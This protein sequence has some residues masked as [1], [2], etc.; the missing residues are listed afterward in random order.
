MNEAVLKAGL[1]A[2]HYSGVSEAL[3]PMTRGMGV[4]FMLHHIAPA[5]GKA[6]DPNGLLSITP[7]FLAASVKRVRERGWDIVSIGEAVDRL[8]AGPSPN[9]R[10]FAVFTIDDGYRDNLTEAYPVMKAANAPFT[11]YV[12]SALPQGEA[13]L[14]WI[15]LEEVIA[16]NPVIEFQDEVIACDSIEGKHAAWAQL[17]PII[18]MAPEDQQRAMVRDL[19]ARY[20]VSQQEIC[21]R[22][23]MTWD[24]VRKLGSDPLVTIGAHTVNHFAV[25][26]LDAARA[27]AEMDEGAQA[28]ARE[29]GKKP[30]HFAYPYGDRASAGPR[31]FAIASELGFKSA[32]TTRKG[33]LTSQHRDHLFALPRVALNGNLQ[34]LH[35]VDVLL[36]G[37]PFFLFNGLKLT[38]TA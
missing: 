1:N 8:E 37:A 7:D 10:P 18:R 11:V 29:T 19:A 14:W 5:S 34:A 9:A 38:V 20:G 36:S 13:E 28:I 3:A 23:A 31:D 4:I 32:V 15:T 30:Q 12:T 6:F 27:R 24:E 17:Y 25:V 16:K 33:M 2:L 26:K 35:Y 21:A 22:E